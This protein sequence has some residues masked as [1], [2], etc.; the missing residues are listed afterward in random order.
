MAARQRA[1]PREWPPD[2][3]V[4]RARARDRAWFEEHPGETAYVRAS[5]PGEFDV[6]LSEHIYATVDPTEIAL[7]RVEPIAPG[8]RLRTR[9]PIERL[10]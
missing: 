10:P 7:V 3:D 8:V 5:I 6:R 1:E 2:P 4:E 9:L